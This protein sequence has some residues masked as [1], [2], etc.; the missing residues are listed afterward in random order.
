MTNDHPD[1][2]PTPQTPGGEA[3][4][5]RHFHHGAELSIATDFPVSTEKIQQLRGRLT[6]RARDRELLD[7]SYRVVDSP[8]GKLLLAATP[9]GLVRVAFESEGFGAVLDSLA[10]HLGPRMMETPEALEP[11]V[12]ELAEYFAGERERFDLVLDRSLSAGFRSTIHHLL[13]DI[14]YG[15][16]WTY[17]EL[18][19]RAGN[20]RAV[21]AVG[22]ACARNPLP[23]IVPCHRVLRSDGSLGGYLGGT[24][25]KRH[26][27]ELEDEA[28]RV[29]P[30][31]PEG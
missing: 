22:T 25:A 21:R 17:K 30:G 24:P 15:R 9:Q 13:P 11:V 31:I 8:V 4:V 20:P 16:T 5:D 19:A 29:T 6:R 14:G 2:D 23:V 26:L 1:T 18:A 12:V 3:R 7:V 27:L 10:E 28:A